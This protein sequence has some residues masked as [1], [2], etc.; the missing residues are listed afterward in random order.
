MK[1][2]N[3]N[4]NDNIYKYLKYLF[5]IIIFPKYIQMIPI[6]IITIGLIL[7]NKGKLYIDKTIAPFIIYSLFHLFSIIVN[8]LNDVELS[9]IIAAINTSLLW[10]FGSIIFSYLKTEKID[11]EQ[12]DKLMYHNMLILIFLGII[13]V[14]IKDTS[15]SNFSIFSRKLIGTDWLFG[16]QSQRFMA[17]MEYS[18]L[19]VLL[20]FIALPFS[21]SYVQQKK[22]K[23][24]QLVFLILSMLPPILTNSRMGIILVAICF[25]AIFPQITS[26]NSKTKIL[27]ILYFGMILTILIFFFHQDLITKI[28][29]IITSRQDS[30]SM[31]SLIY[32]TSIEKTLTQSPFIGSGIKEYFN[33][34]PL[35][36]HST[37]IGIFYKTGIIGSLIALVGFIRIYKKILSIKIKD[38]IQYSISFLCLLIMLCIED[39]DG[40]NWLIILFFITIG[41]Y[42]YQIKTPFENT[43]LK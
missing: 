41:I 20:Y 16:E 33:D 13:M 8:S 21:L 24:F 30:T 35:G 12:I 40:A 2:S 22:G 26:T 17:F 4:S 36:S 6:L 43:I 9:R 25:I 19:V 23:I 37:F 7:K 32:K 11:K 38:N 31:R 3:K 14:L 1:N 34:Y 10:L 39:L 5:L 28:T 18:N 15:Y 42:I 27:F 29:K